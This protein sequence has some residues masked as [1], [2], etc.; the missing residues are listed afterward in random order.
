MHKTETD[1]TA[2]EAVEQE[3]QKWDL[4]YES[5]P[6]TEEDEQTAAFNRELVAVISDLLPHGGSILEAGCGGGYQSLALARTGRFQ[7]ALLDFSE[8]ALDHARRLFERE[9]LTAEYHLDDAF[10]TGDRRYDLVFNAGVLEHYT[11]DEQV[12]MLRGLASRSRRYVLVLVPNSLCYWY[13]IWRLHHSSH[14]NWPFGKEV[15]LADL[16]AMLSA[17]N[18]HFLGH[19]F[20]GA[21]WTETFLDGLGLPPDLRN[22]I[23]EAHHSPL[24]PDSAKTYLVAALASIEPEAPAHG[25][26]ARDGASAPDPELRAALADALALRVGGERRLTELER[27]YK[28]TSNRLAKSREMVWERDTGIAFLKHE[29]EERE[30]SIAFLKTE[31]EHAQNAFAH[32]SKGLAQATDE[33]TRANEDIASLQKD[34]A[35]RRM[36]SRIRTRRWKRNSIACGR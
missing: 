9:R 4:Y 29:I 5:L 10:A 34:S 17:A 16:S 3:R 18:L 30:R 32:A 1:I 24:I 33:L 2:P 19:R 7:T 8:K 20:V 15:P 27:D 21:H 25:W 26:L 11:F 13:W 28:L 22:A 36:N 23:V 31:I 6:L 12:A 14:G 35:W